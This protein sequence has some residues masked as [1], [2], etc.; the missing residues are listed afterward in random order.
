M[1]IKIGS[2]RYMANTNMV[3]LLRYLS[4]FGASFLREFF[5]KDQQTEAISLIRLVWAAIEGDKPD[6]DEFIA[7]AARDKTFAVTALSVRT[8]VLARYSKTDRQGNAAGGKQT[9]D[10]FDVLSLM[11]VAGVDMRL[12]YE[13][14]IF[15]VVEVV[16][17]KLS[18]T[19]A[20]R[21]DNGVEYIK[22]TPQTIRRLKAE[23]SGT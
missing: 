15:M 13:L 1:T 7:V 19:S 10:E 9:I 23:A 5:E 14:P 21:C 16:S 20:A 18:S 8:A 3:V 11:V 12:I 22:A 17:R 6:F 4:T 2:K